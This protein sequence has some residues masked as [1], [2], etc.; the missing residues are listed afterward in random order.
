VKRLRILFSVLGYKP[1]WRFGGPIVSVSAM[2]E[3]LVARGHEVTVFTT[4]ANFDRDLDVD[5]GRYHDVDGVRVRYFRRAAPL[6]RYLPLPAYFA[7]ST[8][9]LYCPEMAGELDRVL[10]DMDLVHTQ[11]PFVYPTVAAARAAFRHGKPLFY[12]QRGVFG[13]GHL[14]FRSLKKRL[15]IALVEAPILRR[16]TT[17]IALT[18]TEVGNYRRLGVDTPCRV[19]PNGVDPLKFAAPVAQDA[20]DAV[21]PADDS[22]LLFLG[23][24]HPTKGV[25]VLLEAFLAA[26]AQLPRT[27]LVIAG[28]DEFG[29]EAQFRE[30]V[31]SAAPSLRV[32]FAGMV[33]GEAKRALLARA[34]LFV[35][36]SAA[37]GFSIAT[38]EAMAAGCAVLLSPACNFPEVEGAAAGRIVEPTAAALAPALIAMSGDREELRRMGQRARALVQARYTWQAACD[39]LLDAYEE[40]IARSAIGS[41]VSQ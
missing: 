34:D 10:P 19:V 31:Q 14:R 2:A 6:T 30:R 1:A 37:E 25:D 13:P 7:K 18:P 3:Q 33:E 21:A 39:A 12:N 24:V 8:G 23:R 4:N 29:L 16:A 36:P 17:L 35:L 40:G 26:Q 20:L 22:V 28:P 11:L 38:L 41:A 5:T 32:R 9:F 15:Y 27:H